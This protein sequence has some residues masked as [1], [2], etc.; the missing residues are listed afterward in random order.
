[1]KKMILLSAGV[2]LI[3][4][5]LS[6]CKKVIK[7]VFGGT[8]ITVAS[9]SV[10]VPAV[11]VVTS[12][13]LEVGTYSYSFNLDSAV[14][15][16]T[17]GLFGAGAVNSVKVKQVLIHISNSDSL[18]NLANFDSA[19]VTL[20]SNTNNNPV[21]LFDL[22]FPDNP[23]SDYTETPTSG[24]ELISYLKG[25]TLTFTLYGMMRRPTTKALD[26][27]ITVTIRAD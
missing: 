27:T 11:P 8:D 12:Y 23:S 9:F 14:R 3:G 15:A 22:G 25:S 2:L 16:S 17:A 21:N 13:E 18:N 26:L 20:V 6:S 7:T 24:P 4:Q 5:G 1:M 10:T 19:L